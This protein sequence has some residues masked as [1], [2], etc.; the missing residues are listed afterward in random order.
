[1]VLT[2]GDVPAFVSGMPLLF[3]G[4]RVVLW[5]AAFFVIIVSQPLAPG[6]AAAVSLMDGAITGL[7]FAL[8]WVATRPALIYA[9]LDFSLL[10]L[11]TLALVEKAQARVR[12]HTVLD[13]NIYGHVESYRRG[14]LYARQGKWALAAL[15]FQ[16]AMVLGPRIAVYYKDLS[17]AQ[18]R[19]GRL[20]QA[21]RTLRMGAEMRPDDAEF[22]AL[23]QAL[24]HS[25]AR[26]DK[27]VVTRR[28][29]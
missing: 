25:A 12:Q 27:G 19:L 10:A 20:P 2:T 22:P 9:G 24:Q 1:V 3:M 11:S 21:E 14:R 15:H 16:R 4:V 8:G 6:A 18:A 13:R 17:A 5:L 7:G 29:K 23:L 26:E 28:P